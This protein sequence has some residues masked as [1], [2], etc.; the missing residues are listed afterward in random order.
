MQTLPWLNTYM[1]DTVSSKSSLLDYYRS[2]KKPVYFFEHAQKSQFVK[3]ANEQFSEEV[4]ATI[5]A[6]EQTIKRCFKLAG[7]PEHTPFLKMTEPI[8]WNQ[9]PNG[10]R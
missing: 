3:V 10:D 2:R 9:S 1:N 8:D 4:K 5:Y 7:N 6:A